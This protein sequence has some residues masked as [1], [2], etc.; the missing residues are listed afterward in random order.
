MG[1]LIKQRSWLWSNVLHGISKEQK[2]LKEKGWVPATQMHPG[3]D[4]YQSLIET[5][6]L[7]I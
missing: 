6:L 5:A 4:Y 2:R 1:T 3:V 7:W